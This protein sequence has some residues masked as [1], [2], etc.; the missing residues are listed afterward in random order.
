M[1]NFQMFLPAIDLHILNFTAL[2]V[3][4]VLQYSLLP[5]ALCNLICESQYILK[6]WRVPKS[7]KNTFY[8]LYHISLTKETLQ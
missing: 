1:L 3:V 6:V 5:L 4:G 7:C 8:A 2:S